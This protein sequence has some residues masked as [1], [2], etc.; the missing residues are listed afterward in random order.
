MEEISYLLSVAQRLR[1]HPR[2][3]IHCGQENYLKIKYVA[4]PI[5]KVFLDISGTVLI[6][7]RAILRENCEKQMQKNN[8]KSEISKAEEFRRFVFRPTLF[9]K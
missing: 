4:A 3:R 6:N 1:E 5:R 7:L 8:D 9:A 2:R